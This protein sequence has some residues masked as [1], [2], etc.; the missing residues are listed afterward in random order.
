MLSD[1]RFALRQLMKAPGFTIT[2]VLTLALGISA[3]VTI[4]ALVD[5]VLLRT[6]AAYSNRSVAIGRTRPPD[7]T[8]LSANRRDWLA[9]ES[10]LKSFDLLSADW[11]LPANLTGEGEP[12][13][14]SGCWVT[15][16]YFAFHG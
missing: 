3:C 7:T 2:V 12:I 1:F 5:S 10:E 13:R 15:P 9:W 11:S 8:P 4:F 14:V 6:Y 16:H